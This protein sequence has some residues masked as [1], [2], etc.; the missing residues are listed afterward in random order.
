M[1]DAQSQQP[2]ERLL[3][4]VPTLS[5]IRVVHTPTAWRCYCRQYSFFESIVY[6]RRFAA[7]AAMSAVASHPQRGATYVACL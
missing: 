2:N 1:E 7:A 6:R 5:S 3:G 4:M